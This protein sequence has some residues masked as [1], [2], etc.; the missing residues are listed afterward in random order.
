VDKQ[1]NE[2]KMNKN[3][4]LLFGISLL[5]SLS[6]GWKKDSIIPISYGQ[7]VYPQQQPL[8]AYLQTKHFLDS[9]GND[10]IELQ[11][12]YVGRSISY[13]QIDSNDWTGEI[14]VIIDIFQSEQ[15]VAQDAYRLPTPILQNGIIEDFYDIK[16]FILPQGEYHCRI[17]LIDLHVSDNSI[18]TN[19]SFLIRP[20][21]AL[22]GAI[23]DIFVAEWATPTRDIT[24][25][26]RSG[27][28]IVP[29]ISSFYPPD[30]VNIPYYFEVYW[31]SSDHKTDDLPAEFLIR[32][33]LLDSSTQEPLPGYTQE[34]KHSVDSH[35]AVFKT[36]S[37][38]ILPTG[39][40]TLKI[41]THKLTGEELAVQF[42]SFQRNNTDE[43]LSY[44]VDL[45]LDSHFQES[46]HPDSTAYYL[47][48]MI[49]IAGQEQTRQIMATLRER[50][51]EKNRRFIQ[52]LWQ[53]SN[54][55]D[56]YDSWMRYK[57]RVQYVDLQFKTHFQAG[58]D[59]DR[60]RVYLQYGPPSRITEREVSASEY[61]YEMWEYNRIGNYSNRKFI[62]YNPDLLHNTY[63]LL[64]S[65]MVGELKNPSWQYELNSR[66]TK[67]GSV[68]DPNEY[69]PDSW[70]NNARQLLGK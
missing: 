41:S 60:G 56:A 11:F 13:Q 3:L 10:Y 69:N 9:Q 12:H 32:T 65:D 44:N 37:I 50:D 15:L 55:V 38:D 36:L 57:E 35:V 26:S 43:I 61:P 68:D 33:Q 66:N 7:V 40:Y 27:Y 67:R 48:S 5:F 2:L 62:F 46:I 14:A 24:P 58:F 29:R 17:E 70:G 45:L 51:T 8:T 28:D 30:L 21:L 4:F 52:S 59:T 64:H 54:P 6:L 31:L 47:A 1:N 39:S 18:K 20:N 49:P 34:S 16:R 23:S 22:L 19:F 42:Y 53:Q 25:F 63:R